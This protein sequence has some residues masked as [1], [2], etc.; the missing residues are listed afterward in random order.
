MRARVPTILPILL[1]A[2]VVGIALA[3]GAWLLLPKVAPAPHAAEAAELLNS[4]AR[5]A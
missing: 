2:F 5:R 1:G 3:A 4:V